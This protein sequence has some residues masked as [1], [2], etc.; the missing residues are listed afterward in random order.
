[1][2]PNLSKLYMTSLD[3]LIY[4][5]WRLIV[6]YISLFCLDEIL[7]DLISFF[8][9]RHV[10]ELQ[11]LSHISSMRVEVGFGN[12]ESIKLSMGHSKIGRNLSSFS[13]FKL[14]SKGPFKKLLTCYSGHDFFIRAPKRV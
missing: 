3:I 9:K 5:S 11:C 12:G 4:F 14:L 6:N 7:L 10:D 8:F 13:Y 2:Y 1:M